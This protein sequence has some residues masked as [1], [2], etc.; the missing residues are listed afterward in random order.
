[1]SVGRKKTLGDCKAVTAVPLGVARRVEKSYCL[2][3]QGQAVF[4]GSLALTLKALRSLPKSGNTQTHDVTSQKARIIKRVL[5][6]HDLI[7]LKRNILL[8]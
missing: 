4:S 2:H 3:T 7:K 8:H 5:K 1:M 6:T